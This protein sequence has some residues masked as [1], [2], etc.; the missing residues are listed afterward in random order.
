MKLDTFTP[1][2]VRQAELERSTSSAVDRTE[3]WS[4]EPDGHEILPQGL[5]ALQ[6]QC[7]GAR[8]GKRDIEFE[9]VQVGGSLTAE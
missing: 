2:V 8:Q 6:R 4:S 3:V 9:V 7:V 1:S 5:S